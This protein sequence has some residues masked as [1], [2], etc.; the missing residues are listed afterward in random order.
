MRIVSRWTG[1]LAAAT[2]ALATFLPAGSAEAFPPKI[3][4]QSAAPT[5]SLPKGVTLSPDG[6]RLFVTN[7]GLKDHGNITVYDA[8]DLKKLDTVDV[9]G[10]VVESA[11]SP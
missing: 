5:G 7:Y 1:A 10:V 2:A 11:I 3:D 4:V 8:A 9:P 6:R